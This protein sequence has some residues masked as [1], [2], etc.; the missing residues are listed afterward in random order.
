MYEGHVS[1]TSFASACCFFCVAGRASFTDKPTTHRSDALTLFTFDLEQDVVL[2]SGFSECTGC[3]TPPTGLNPNALHAH[4]DHVLRIFYVFSNTRMFN[5][6]LDSTVRH[7]QQSGYAETSFFGGVLLPGFFQTQQRRIVQIVSGSQLPFAMYTKRAIPHAAVAF[8]EAAQHWQS[9]YVM[10]ANSTDAGIGVLRVLYGSQAADDG[11]FVGGVAYSGSN[12]DFTAGATKNA[13]NMHYTPLFESAHVL[14][15]VQEQIKKRHYKGAD[16]TEQG[17]FATMRLHSFALLN[18]RKRVEIPDTKKYADRTE[19]VHMLLSHVQD[20]TNILQQEN[21]ALHDQVLSLVRVNVSAAGAVASVVQLLSIVTHEPLDTPHSVLF[22]IMPHDVHVDTP[23]NIAAKSIVAIMVQRGNT[24]TVHLSNFSCLQ[25]GED[26]YDAA[27]ESCNC[28]PGTLPVCLPCSTNCATGRFVVDPNPMLCHQADLATSAGASGPQHQR[29]RHNLVCMPCTGT[30]F[31]TDGTV[32]GLQQCPS[33]RPIT[34]KLRASAG[35]ECSCPAGHVYSSALRAAYVVDRDSISRVVDFQ[36]D[37]I[38]V[39]ESCSDSQVCTPVF[40]QESHRIQCPAHT[41]SKTSDV[42]IGG[43]RPEL[44]SQTAPLN[45]DDDRFHNVY[46]G[47]FCNDGFYRTQDRSDS[48][49]VDAADFIYKYAWNNSVLS[50]QAARGNTR[51]HTRIEVCRACEAGWVCQ[52]SLRRQ[53]N[54]VSSDSAAG[55]THC[56]CRPGFVRVDNTTCGVC[57]PGTLCPGGIDVPVLCNSNTANDLHRFCPCAPGS[58]R[59]A[60]R[61]RCETCAPNFYCPGFANMTG[62]P[63]SST[64]YARRCPDNTTSLA[65]SQSIDQCFCGEGTFLLHLHTSPTCVPCGTGYYCP[66]FGQGRIA[67]P[68][69]TTT[70]AGQPR[71]STVSDCVCLDPTMQLLSVQPHQQHAQGSPDDKECACRAGWLQRRCTEHT[72]ATK[73]TTMPAR[74]CIYLTCTQRHRDIHTC[75]RAPC[76]VQ[77]GGTTCVWVSYSACSAH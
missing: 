24:H 54:A 69:H 52:G 55:S 28:R 3:C 26:L 48:Y 31:C 30:L 10:T 39:C 53:C 5:A 21:D 34:M 11:Y 71:A 8:A 6:T 60:V 14:L 68:P 67:C 44:W 64:I 58:I 36:Q 16:T 45:S 15:E 43:T 70:S 76:Y 18:N 57:P 51:I 7:R 77:N 33:I 25:C 40:T 75:V 22:S 27:T 9:F 41:S 35:F 65:A 29:P 37:N 38:S 59:N 13:S 1:C 17:G 56:T 61:G 50:E 32:T 73:K 47:C 72:Y 74:I 49:L 23:N 42:P 2:V 20:H 12:L 4:L 46:Q 63:P 66:G 62:V 19:H